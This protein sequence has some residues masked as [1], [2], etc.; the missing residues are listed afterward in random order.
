MLTYTYTYNRNFDG[1]SLS[2]VLKEMNDLD[3]MRAKFEGQK[4]NEVI[5]NLFKQWELDY[6]N[7][8]N[9]PQ[10]KILK[11]IVIMLSKKYLF[12]HVY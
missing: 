2:N 8:T 10:V 11:Q 6:P 7:Y 5:T 9:L 4:P 1:A 12:N 3:K